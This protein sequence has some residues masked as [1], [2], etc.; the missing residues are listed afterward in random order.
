V[1]LQ[2]GTFGEESLLEAA[3]RQRD[4]EWQATMDGVISSTSLSL[5]AERRVVFALNAEVAKLKDEL[6]AAKAITSAP[7]VADDAQAQLDAAHESRRAAEAVNEALRA[8]VKLLKHALEQASEDSTTA[9]EESAQAC[10][11]ADAKTADAVAAADALRADVESLKAMLENAKEDS[12]VA[13]HRA[14][15][16]DTKTAAVDKVM[17]DLRA[18]IVSMTTALARATDKAASAEKA[19]E[20]QRKQASAVKQ[21]T[22]KDRLASQA[23][24]KQLRT[25]LE[26]ERLLASSARQSSKESAALLE[27]QRAETVKLQEACEKMHRHMAT[28]DAVHDEVQVHYD[29]LYACASDMASHLQTI[30]VTPMK[31]VALEEF[32]QNHMNTI[33]VATSTTATDVNSDEAAG[34]FKL[35]YKFIFAVTVHNEHAERMDEFASKYMDLLNSGQMGCLLGKGNMPSTGA[36]KAWEAVKTLN[37]LRVKD[38]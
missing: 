29:K 9:R 24:L 37:R 7:T 34:I 33:C 13:T 38:V 31:L 5:Y 21:Q 28:R 12:K 4:T 14:L 10:K 25:E 6:V 19:L 8:E 26:E 23:A 30:I 3:L 17:D 36:V 27:E 20:E 1:K 22:A 16:A 32:L 2:F 35:M 18:E 15:A 11:L